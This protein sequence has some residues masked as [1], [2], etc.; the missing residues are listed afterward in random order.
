MNCAASPRAAPRAKRARLAAR[1]MRREC[2][3]GLRAPKGT[4]ALRAIARGALRQRS[5]DATAHAVFPNFRDVDRPATGQAPQ[6]V[7]PASFLQPAIHRAVQIHPELR[8]VPNQCPRRSAIGN[9]TALS[10]NDAGHRVHRNVDL[11]RKLGGRDAE[12][13][14]LFR[15]VFSGM[16]SVYEAWRSLS[17]IISDLNVDGARQFVRPSEAD[18]PLIVDAESKIVRHGCPKGLPIGFQA[19]PP[20]QRAGCRL[21]AGQGASRLAGRNAGTLLDIAARRQTVR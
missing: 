2:P 20:N 18:P 17:M 10:C 13:T 6:F 3:L 21:R 19:M 15:K 8:I 9:D 12:L 1:T 11:P 16:R 14:Q 7:A 5:L 4:R